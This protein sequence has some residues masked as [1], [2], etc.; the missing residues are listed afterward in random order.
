MCARQ[1]GGG[2][3]RAE[4]AGLTRAR[5]L[6][7]A[8]RDVGINLHEQR[9]F[10]GDAARAHDLVDTHAIFLDAL[11]DRA[12]AKRGRLDQGAIDV[13]PRRIEVLAEQQ[14]GEPLVDENGPIAVVPVERQKAGLP[15]TLLRRLGGQF[16][17]QRRVAAQ[18]DFDPP[19]ED[20]ADG[21]LA[22]FD[23][24]EAGQNGAFHDAADAGNIGDRLFGRND[25][26]VAGRRAD[27]LD[28]RR[29]RARRSRSRRSERRILRSRSECLARSPSFVAQSEHSDPAGSVAS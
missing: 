14:P 2:D 1:H 11:D 22:G 24:E 29:L 3:R 5:D 25:R 17:V 28:Q 18:N 4:S 12:R 23:A 27:H 7:D 10:L 21:R 20:V 9:I 19:F 8:A 16:G 13:R 15:W 26:A 6:H